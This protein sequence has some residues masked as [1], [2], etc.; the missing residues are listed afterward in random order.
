MINSSIY[1]FLFGIF[2]PFVLEGLLYQSYLFLNPNSNFKP[3]F[4]FFLIFAPL[5]I[6]MIFLYFITPW[7]IFKYTQVENNYRS[8]LSKNINNI[9][10]QEKGVLDENEEKIIRQELINTMIPDL[11]SAYRARYIDSFFSRVMTTSNRNARQIN[12]LSFFETIFLFGIISGIINVINSILAL[13]VHFSSIELQFANIQIDQIHNASNAFFFILLFLMIAISGFIMAT[14]AKRRI[15][16]LIPAVVP[17]YAH[18]RTFERIMEKKLTAQLIASYDL[19]S[20]IG[21]DLIR[22]DILVSDIMEKSGLSIQLAEIIDE[23]SQDQAGREL[24]WE[25]YSK[26]LKKKGISNNKIETISESFLESSVIKS[27]E[28][29]T[30]D[31]R[32]FESLKSDLSYVYGHIAKWDEKTNEERLTA[33]MLIYRAT[34]TLFRGI[35]RKTRGKM[36]NFGS[37]V[38]ALADMNLINNDE[39]I[40][41]NSA[42]KQRNYIL[43]RTG[44]GLSLSQSYMRQFYECI[45]SIITRAGADLGNN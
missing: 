40:I 9:F 21:N 16:Y 3:D 24:V 11:I 15:S 30:F 36:G 19:E 17:G 5:L 20:M 35:L 4:L 38:L 42:R 41:L 31:F 22:N 32:E 7:F 39:Q 26:I 37:M 25:S 28:L 1:R 27:A 43:H 2:F 44:E 18:F 33:F 34:E 8:G 6:P 14:I 12:L 13:Y 29:F 23:Y 10:L 45:T